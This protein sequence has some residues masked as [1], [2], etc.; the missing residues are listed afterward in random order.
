MKRINFD[1]NFYR[2]LFL[3]SIPIAVQQL[4][5]AL[6]YFIDNIMIGSL[7]DDAIVGVVNANQ[8]AF[9]IMVIMLGICGTGWVF[10]ARFNG[11]GDKN[12]IRKTLGVCLAGTLIVGAL[13]F[14]LTQ[15]LPRQLI[16][17]FNPKPEV[18]ASGGDYIR[19]VGVSYLFM[20]VS[21]S[22]ANVL[23]GCQKT[24]LPMVASGIAII[25]NAFLNYVLIFGKLGFPEMGVK[26]A[27]IGT[28][29][30]AFIDAA[31]LMIISNVKKNE[32]SGIRTVVGR[33]DYRKGFIR[34][35]VRVGTP[36]MI[37]ELLW[38]LS[39][40]MLVLLYNRMAEG[41]ATA[42]SV[43]SAL[44]RLA[45][46]VY[47]GI[48]HSA[49][50]MV[51]NQLG[52][53]NP[54]KAYVYG[55]RFLRIAPIST[56]FVG[57]ILIALLPTFL[58]FYDISKTALDLTRNVVYTFTAIAWL[59]T[60]NFTNLIGII[61]GGGDTRYGMKIDLAGSWLITLPVSFVT[62]LV[63]G[64]PVYLV[65]LCGIVSGDT[66]KLI[67]GLRRFFSKKWMHDITSSVRS[68]TTVEH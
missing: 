29:V 55:K 44:E 20:A 36:M 45:Y 67:L 59:M 16:G 7:G 49:G 46:V 9:F 54:D 21:L 37:N 5:K 15:A 60:I 52:E 10:V 50:V 41:T 68:A 35:F 32:V 51:G 24:R 34:Q 19:I 8:I 6:M 33:R 4:L 12:G 30:G 3:V 25:V 22:Y 1:K 47:I 64:W 13:F 42:M 56:V 14:V 11:E 53:G 23:K 27:A 28:A 2:Q 57:G 48:A 66:F 17:M 61:R 62:G 58:S 38:A 18:M 43:F 40:M 39:A 31:L 26:G 65:Y 63:L